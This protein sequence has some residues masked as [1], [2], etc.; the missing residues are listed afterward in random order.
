MMG[1]DVEDRKLRVLLALGALASLVFANVLQHHG[2]LPLNRPAP[3]RLP[4]LTDTARHPWLTEALT[5]FPYIRLLDVHV[6]ICRAQNTSAVF[7]AAAVEIEGRAPE[8]WRDT[9]R[10]HDADAWTPS[11]E[12]MSQR[13]VGKFI[14]LTVQVLAAQLL[15]YFACAVVEVIDLMGR[16]PCGAR[17]HRFVGGLY[18]AA[19]LID[20]LGVLVWLLFAIFAFV[21]DFINTDWRSQWTYIET[22]IS[23]L[24]VRP[25]D[26]SGLVCSHYGRFMHMMHAPCVIG[27]VF[28]IL[29]KRHMRASSRGKLPTLSSRSLL[30][31][32]TGYHLF[33]QV[34]PSITMTMMHTTTTLIITNPQNN[35]LPMNPQSWLEINYTLNRGAIPYPWYYDMNPPFG[36]AFILYFLAVNSLIFIVV[37]A[38]HR[39]YSPAGVEGRDATVRHRRQMI[40]T[41]NERRSA[42]TRKTD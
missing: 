24:C 19:P 7:E 18:M 35:Q 37:L 42:R 40:P 34:A 31:V 8:T 2:P 5:S 15:Y 13:S 41:P 29:A 11:H 3:I 16:A 30:L 27:A 38:V 17:Y 26:Q 28:D 23:H 22:R 6:P 10:V 14:F 21:M 32:L 9:F 25:W 39:L 4:T 33:F 20:G 1:F 36:V 12:V